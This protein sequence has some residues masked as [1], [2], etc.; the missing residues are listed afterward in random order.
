MA[1]TVV[2]DTIKSSVSGPA[3][4]QNT[5]GTEVGQLCKAWARFAA[6]ASPSVTASFNV[7][8]ITYNAAGDYTVNFTNALTDGNYSALS[9]AATTGGNR[10]VSFSQYTGTAPTSS[11]CRFYYYDTI[12]GQTNPPSGYAYIAIFR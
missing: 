7:S 4:F 9:Q 2:T 11:A 6:S 10:A 8:S 5:S 12:I 1:G 3:V